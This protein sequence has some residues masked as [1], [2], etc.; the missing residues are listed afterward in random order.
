[1]DDILG[2]SIAQLGARI[3]FM[4]SYARALVRSCGQRAAITAVGRNAT[5]VRENIDEQN[6]YLRYSENLSTTG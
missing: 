2:R 5:Q 6:K 3:Y 4:R 1:M